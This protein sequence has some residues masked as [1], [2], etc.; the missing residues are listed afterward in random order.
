MLRRCII[1]ASE[2]DKVNDG[3][4]LIAVSLQ[5][6]REVVVDIHPARAEH[7]LNSEVI[8]SQAFAV[9]RVIQTR[10]YLRN[11]DPIE[12]AVLLRV[13]QYKNV[14]GRKARHISVLSK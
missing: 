2:T 9:I 14:V 3:I 1:L 12:A 11:T 8:I 10:K 7:L 13:G 4:H 5:R 6:K